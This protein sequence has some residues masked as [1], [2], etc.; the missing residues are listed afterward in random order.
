VVYLLDTNVCIHLRRGDP[1]VRQRFVSRRG[2]GLISVV[3]YGELLFGVERSESPTA[4]AQL[5]T[6]LNL[7]RVEPVPADAGPVYGRIRAQL[8]RQGLMIGANDLWIAAHAIAGGYTLVSD[9][10]REFARV[11]GLRLENWVRDAS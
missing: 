6:V 1:I 7:V 3:T 11:E 10:T 9:N 8:T 2:E 5:D 4:L